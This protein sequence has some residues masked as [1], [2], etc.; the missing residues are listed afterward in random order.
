MPRLAPP[1]LP[2][3]TRLLNQL[4]TRL[5]LARLRRRYSADL[6]AQRAGISRRTLARMEQGDPAVA[7]GIY[8]RVLQVL[9]L[10]QDLAQIAVDDELGRRL[11]DAGLAPKQRA[12]KQ[13]T[14]K[15]AATAEEISE[16]AAEIHPSGNR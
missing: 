13:R 15:A 7:L 3:L 8:A 9:R 10:E 14:I 5:K 2:R 4:G 11:Q 6:V 16:A 12:P 1:I